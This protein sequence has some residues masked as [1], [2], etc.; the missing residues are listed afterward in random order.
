M[1]NEIT[2]EGLEA[3]AAQLEQDAETRAAKL[4][5]LIRAF[6]RIIQAREPRKFIRQPCEFGDE[7]GHYD[8]SFPPKQEHRDYTGP[9]LL[10][11]YEEEIE[12]VRTSS[13]FYYDYRIVT[14]NAGLYVAADGSLWGADRTGTGSL[15]Q[16]AAHPGDCGVEVTIDY[17]RRDDVSI[18]A[19]EIAEKTLRDLAFPL[20]AAAQSAAP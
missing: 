8:N 12:E 11:I 10:E 2:I 16:F 19:L 3:M 14:T 20:V 18:E 17:D 15:G 13:G 9:R 4:R 6:A 1:T 5:R 7:A